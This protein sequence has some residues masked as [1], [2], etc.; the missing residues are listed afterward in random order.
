MTTPS[1]HSCHPSAQNTE[2]EEPPGCAALWV[3]IKTN[4][5]TNKTTSQRLGWSSVERGYV[6]C[7]RLL[8]S[9]QHFRKG[10]KMKIRPSEEDWWLQRGGMQE[11]NEVSGHDV[12]VELL[13]Q[14]LFGWA[15]WCL[16]LRGRIQPMRSRGKTIS[17]SL[18]PAWVTQWGPGQPVLYREILSQ[19]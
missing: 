15:W 2:Q 7:S 8:D 17:V 3:T 5:E 14:L 10:K 6:A 12:N 11:S 16:P 1:W 9:Q 19:K 4:I 18:K 13:E